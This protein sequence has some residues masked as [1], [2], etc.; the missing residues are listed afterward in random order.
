V[1]LLWLTVAEKRVR[2]RLDT[3]EIPHNADVLLF[4]PPDAA[5]LKTH[6]TDTL[7]MPS[8]EKVKGLDSR[9]KMK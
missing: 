1:V 7:Y 9:D 2:L 4:F 5:V 8:M 6:I 3:R